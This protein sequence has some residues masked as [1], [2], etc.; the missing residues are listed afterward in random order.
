MVV[1]PD[2]A[3]LLPSLA[4]VI[5]GAPHTVAVGGAGTSDECVANVC[6]PFNAPFTYA[7]SVC[8]YLHFSG[9]C[10]SDITKFSSIV[11]TPAGF[12]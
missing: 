7:C 9:V 10:V 6:T 11:G 2:G 4:A 1:T 8:D 12:N 3:T 5:A